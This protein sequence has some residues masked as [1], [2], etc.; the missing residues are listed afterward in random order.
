MSPEA[1]NGGAAVLDKP[2]EVTLTATG[3]PV[4]PT[5]APLILNDA[6]FDLNGVNLRCLVKHLEVIPENKLVTVTSFCAE[7]DY[8]GVT[9]W[10][11]KVT[12]HQS[13]D[14][15]AVYATLNAAYTN[16]VSTGALATFTARPHA[17]Q[18]ASASNPIITGNVV[19]QPF[20]LLIGDAGAASDITIDWNL[21]AP[22]TVNSGAIVATGA[23]SG[24][25]GF[26]TPAGAA[27]PA[28]LAA[29]TGITATPATTW[30]AGAY[31]ITA[32]L[33]ANNWNGTTWVT[34]KHP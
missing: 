3:D 1:K 5:A 16:Y 30:A 33:L 18:V 22:P 34:G 14:P 23:T 19:P 32:D 26:Y 6:Y 27:T 25:P 4:P 24:A 31:V 7:V 21:A 2:P 17:S 12:F 11:L 13:F 9:K 29:L 20:E 28:N 15:G 8:V 10:H